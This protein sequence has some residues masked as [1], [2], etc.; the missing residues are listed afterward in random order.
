MSPGVTA[1]VRNIK[2]GLRAQLWPLPTVAIVVAVALGLVLPRVDAAVDDG[3]P[4]W[5]TGVIFGGDGNAASTVLD[6]VASSLIT[7]TSL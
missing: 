3:L 4:G 2:D 1:A 6:A 5:L 7:V